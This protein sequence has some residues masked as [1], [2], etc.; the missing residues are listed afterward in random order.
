M[1]YSILII[2]IFALGGT[3]S[4]GSIL[5]KSDIELKVGSNPVSILENTDNGVI[6]IFCA[7][8]DANKNKIID[9]GE[10]RPSW[11][12]Y[13]PNEGEPEKVMDFDS[14]FVEPFKPGFSI[15]NDNP[16]FYIPLAGKSEND[17]FT[18][19]GILKIIVIE[20]DQISEIDSEIPNGE[21]LHIGFYVGNAVSVLRKNGKDSIKIKN[22][23]TNL[24][25]SFEIDGDILSFE[26]FAEDDYVYLAPLYSDG[27]SSQFD[28]ISIDEEGNYERIIEGQ[29]T[30]TSANSSANYSSYNDKLFLLS[31]NSE[32]ATFYTYDKEQTAMKVRVWVSENGKDNFIAGITD[33]IQVRSKD[34][35]D[36]FVT[37]L[38]YGDIKRVHEMHRA[39]FE[40]GYMKRVGDYF[41]CASAENNDWG[42]G[43][44]AVY[45]IINKERRDSS[46]IKQAFVEYNP[47]GL[48]DLGTHP[49]NETY[50][51]CQGLDNNGNGIIEES[52]GDT[53]TTITTHSSGPNLEV[54]NR[55][56]RF[57]FQLNVPLKSNMTRLDH[58]AADGRIYLPS[59]NNIY[60]FNTALQ[61]ISDTLV[62]DMYVACVY[63][64]LDYMMIG[65]RDLV[66]EKS[67]IRIIKRKKFYAQEEV[68]HNVVDC[69]TYKN[70]SGLGVVSI[71]EGTFGE[72]DSKLNIIKLNSKGVTDNTVLDI[73][74]GAASIVANQDQT[75]AAVVMHGSHEVH[76]LNLL[77]G[78][79]IKT[80]PTE[81]SGFGGPRDAVFHN[82]ILY[83]TTYSNRVL[84]LDLVKSEQVGYL[85]V[86][87]DTEAIITE[88]NFV[89]V[90]NSKYADKE[91]NNR[92]IA[93]NIDNITNV[94]LTQ[95][96]QTI[97]IY[98]HPVVN[99]FNIVSDDISGQFYLVI[100]D[101]QG[102]V[103]A[104]KSGYS[105]GAIALNIEE[106]GLTTGT[107]TAIINGIRTV[108]FVV[109]K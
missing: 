21:S 40:V 34:S 98:P 75:E 11:W 56:H 90:A 101:G 81:T 55:P 107:Y 106:L 88:N 68:G 72:S 6:S 15:F 76:I 46:L 48:F 89:L 35:K 67:Y 93:Y 4:N 71:S 66:N 30:W 65:Q 47:V 84:V 51:V 12:K 58:N 32:Y 100:F 104:T 45:N 108:R 96:K 63:A 43:K 50:T 8:V 27:D 37:N 57:D 7:G 31:E 92:L 77:T 80:I 83:V 39:A 53:P 54:K 105:S 14:Y 41:Y 5:T 73:G 79:I 52:D 87:G 70:D 99:D 44:I 61:E 109:G 36:I 2:I 86:D 23:K 13:N 59:G 62:A 49:R 20:S 29:K 69:I 1:K 3:L 94:E 64:Y 9:E 82:D 102:K 16:T 17:I 33:D 24:M 103:I 38:E 91:P 95:T 18:V 26:T 97:R 42:Y 60:A 74:S 28:I 22:E 10:E 19:N 85:K 25:S 78:K